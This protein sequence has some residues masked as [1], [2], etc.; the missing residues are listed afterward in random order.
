MYGIDGVLVAE[1]PMVYVLMTALPVCHCSRPL[2][3]EHKTPKLH[4]CGHTIKFRG[5]QTAPDLLTLRTA[6]AAGWDQSMGSTEVQRVY[7]GERSKHTR[8]A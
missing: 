7:M 5:R 8:E 1:L 3:V 2:F 6:S 4:T